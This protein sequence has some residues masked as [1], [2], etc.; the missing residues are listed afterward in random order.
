MSKRG[1]AVIT[2]AL[3]IWVAAIPAFGAI[4]Y[5]D[6]PRDH[7]AYEAIESLHNAGLVEGYPD[8]TF[9][10]ERTFTRYEMAMVF[11]R[12]LE[13]LDK[14]IDLLAGT[15]VDVDELI[16]EF[17]SELGLINAL[18]V[19]VNN[20]QRAAAEAKDAA[21][22]AGERA[23]RARLTAEQALSEA[24]K[25]SDEAARAAA[26]AEV[27]GQGEAG[28]LEAA[29]QAQLTAERA[30][31]AAKDAEALARKASELAV[32]ARS[33]G[34]AQRALE[35]AE[36]AVTQA[37]RT[38]DFALQ[39]A[40]LANEAHQLALQA[41]E[42]L[43]VLEARIVPEISGNLKANYVHWDGDGK[44]IGRTDEDAEKGSTLKASMDVTAKVQAS[45]DVTVTGTIGV[46]ARD[47]LDE[48]P[49]TFKVTKAS[50]AATTEDKFVR[51]ISYGVS[52]LEYDKDGKV[53][54]G[55]QN[56]DL[57]FGLPL[58]F[59]DLGLDLGF[60]R[61]QND[62]KKDFV[63]AGF[64]DADIFGFNAD[65]HVYADERHDHNTD[66]AYRVAVGRT[67]DL[68]LP[69]TVGLTYAAIDETEIGEETYTSVSAGVKDYAVG[70][71]LTV[72]AGVSYELNP[73]KDAAK[74]TNPAQWGLQLTDD[75]GRPYNVD[76][77]IGVDVEAGVQVFDA[78]KTTGK[79]AYAMHNTDDDNTVNRVDFGVDFEYGLNVLDSDVTV[80]LGLLQVDYSDSKNDFEY[81]GSL[82]TKLSVGIARA[83][84]GGE[85]DANLTYITGRGDDGKAKKE[86]TDMLVQAAYKYPVASGMD[87]TVGAKWADSKGNADADDDYT[88]SG[89]HAGLN[90]EF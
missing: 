59:V 5:P 70:D 87:L 8:G 76:S 22:T 30:Y 43:D 81:K 14:R 55:K 85:V 33:S 88:V 35:V 80:G 64:A 39:T 41:N 32:E 68:G 60:E 21:E 38:K 12:I 53:A 73:L 19:A 52:D 24:R 15:G 26:L 77:K 42:R 62:E 83:L 45:E 25:A 65:F 34:D 89:V 58:G 47:V 57:N 18:T 50:V 16:A 36:Q 37:E 29:Q 61:K 31:Q 17:G 63:K 82:R 56:L 75:A 72:G 48:L 46:G 49:G 1:L 6:V 3:M 84:L 27:G 67:F 44:D 78:L 7:W 66:L 69:F 51:N 54:K 4:P 13:R 90:V 79:L 2:A 86:A 23:Y 28:A 11:S 40:R 10:G 71:R 20:A 74:W 9:G